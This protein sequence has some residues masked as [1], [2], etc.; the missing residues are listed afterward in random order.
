MLSSTVS[1]ALLLSGRSDVTET[2]KFLEMMDKFFDCFNVT[3]PDSG[4]HKRNK[5]LEPWKKN[6]FRVEVRHDV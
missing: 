5:Y 6:D 4:A 2:A 1:N 3:N